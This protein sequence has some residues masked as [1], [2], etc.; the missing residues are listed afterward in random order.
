M[1]RK[2]DYR[3]LACS[4]MLAIATGCTA[5]KA[6]AAPEQ[7]ALTPEDAGAMLEK[8]ATA[9]REKNFTGCAQALAPLH[10]TAYALQHN[11][12]YTAARCF[13]LAGKP[14]DALALLDRPEVPRMILLADIDTDPALA[15][16]R[17]LPAWP[18]LHGRLADRE[19]TLAASMDTDLRK[20][21]IARATREIELNAAAANREDKKAGEAAKA[22]HAQNLDWLE[23]VLTE[24]GWP[25][26][27]QVGPDG[28][29]ATAMLVLNATARPE[30]QRKALDLMTQAGPTEYVPE[31]FA[32]ITD[33]V[34]LNEDKPQRF[35][36]VFARSEKGE[37]SM[38][39]AESASEA[40]LDKVRR[41]LG[42]PPIAEY[43]ES[44]L[45][46]HGQTA[47]AQEATRQ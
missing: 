10:Q 2:N 8:A 33:R 46:Q 38:R 18:A 19:K 6:S 30:L 39:P 13:A 40:E 16:V 47:D 20:E 45:R 32:R 4:L 9:Y 34:L 42:L 37:I 11:T 26:I 12:A 21:I 43:R 24:K 3:L 17:E 25:G 35:G 41:T 29:S 23:Q 28:N 44:I 36:T 31:D 22:Q 14:E 5:D 7:S 1:T 15:S 27:T